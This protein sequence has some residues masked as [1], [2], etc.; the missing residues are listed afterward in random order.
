MW[1]FY[2][3]TADSTSAVNVIEA[4]RNPLPIKITDSTV[5]AYTCDN[6]SSVAKIFLSLN[7]CLVN[8]SLTA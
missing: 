8:F 1:L 2:L 7:I 6:N 4:Q 5:A 3:L